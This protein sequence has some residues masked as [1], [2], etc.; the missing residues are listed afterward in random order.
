MMVSST[1]AL[2]PQVILI[3]LSMMYAVAL[4]ELFIFFNRMSDISGVVQDPYTKHGKPLKSKADR[5]KESITILQKL[6]E[7]GIPTNEPGYVF[8]KQQLDTWIQG[9][10]RWEGRV[11]FP[12]FQRRAELI[13]PVRSDRVVNM[14]I[15]A[16]RKN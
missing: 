8:T 5:V 2:A 11:D 14:T 7:L 15:F 13:L 1:A 3:K 16:P 4:K 9:G 10:D 12:R 6:K